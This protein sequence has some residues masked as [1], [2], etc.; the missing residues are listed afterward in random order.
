MSGTALDHELVRAYLCE[1]DA[2]IRGLP[3]ERAR[4]LKEQITAH[5][6]DALAPGA[7]DLTVA[8]TLRRLGS[9][10]DL[11]AEAGALTPA[12]GATPTSSALRLFLTSLRPRTWLIA[13]FAVILIAIAAKFT[14]Y[15]LSV[16]PL[17]F[18]YG[19]D[20]WYPQDVRHQVVVS[21]G[22]TVQNTTPIRSGQRQGYVVDIY[23]GTKVTQTI[24]GDASG[25]HL[26][27][28]NPGG[29]K[30]HLAVSRSYTDIA[31]GV[32]GESAATH[33]A[34]TLPVSIPP[35]QSRLVRV[36]WT[37][38]LCLQKGEQNGIDLLYLRVR[39]GWF[40]RTEIIPQQAWYLSGPSHGRCTG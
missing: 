29:P 31:N 3:P 24:L 12:P 17:Q 11:A 15:Y 34:F 32:I 33:L 20:W 27:W 16:P 40:V 25:P 14:D 2:A 9:P 10:P 8:A 5:L 37:S 7:D 22:S 1:L 30:E 19:A 35:F 13:A 21:A 6:D 36:T 4:E 18:N 39:V 26:G 38:D 23:N 28:D